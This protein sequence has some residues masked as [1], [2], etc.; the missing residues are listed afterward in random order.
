MSVFSPSSAISIAAPPELVWE[1]LTDTS[2]WPVWNE[3]TPH[4][5]LTSKSAD[6]DPG[7]E[8]VLQ[9]QCVYKWVVQSK[10]AGKLRSVP[11]GSYEGVIEI[12]VP[13]SSSTPRDGADADADAGPRPRGEAA[14]QTWRIVW[15]QRLVPAFLLRTRRI[16]EIRRTAEG[17]RYTTSMTFDG[18]LAWPVKIT[19]GGMV[20]DGLQMC[21]D[22]LKTEAEKR[23][24][25]S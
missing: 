8:S 20:T 1:L 21:A 25:Q 15:E 22:G 17:C 4:S 9:L 2:T 18:P 12:T 5:T 14:D 16:N 13:E 11:G 19:S 10:A 24:R 7:R 6:F 3:F 23:A